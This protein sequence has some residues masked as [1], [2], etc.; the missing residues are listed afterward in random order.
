MGM[1]MVGYMAFGPSRLEV[2]SSADS[3]AT[4]D[5]LRGKVM[6][7]RKDIALMVEGE[8]P[9]DVDIKFS[10][11][12]IVAF[13]MADDGDV[14]DEIPSIFHPSDAEVTD[15]E[16]LK[17]VESLNDLWESAQYARDAMIR[18]LAEDREVGESQRIIVS[19]GEPTWG[20]EPVGSGFQS[21]KD[22][23]AHPFAEPLG[24][25]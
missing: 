1:D 15:D 12:W 24:I 10:D 7:V 18:N 20:D 13:E 21:L 17:E 2:A 4:M 9:D 11:E 16:I 8:S 25:D 22:L 23:V 3:G 19:A 6:E 14:P 5:A